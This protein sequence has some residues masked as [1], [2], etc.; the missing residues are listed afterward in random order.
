[1]VITEALTADLLGGGSLPDRLGYLDEH[2]LASG[3]GLSWILDRAEE[4]VH[5][6]PGDADELARLCDASASALGLP[7]ITGRARYL[8]ARVC[9]ERGELEQALAL[10]AEAHDAW[11]FAGDGLSAI[12]TNLGRMGVLD[13]LGRHRESAS[14]GEDLLRR[15]EELV[16]NDSEAELRELI[17]GTTLN[18][19]GV[20]YSFVGQHERALEAY[21]QAEATY[22]RLD[23]QAEIGKP[24]ANRGI[25]Q[26]ALGRS[27]EALEALAEATAVFTAAGDPLWAAKCAGNAA[28]A[29][30]ELGELTEALR[31]LEPA[32][33]TLDE[34]G[35]DM[36][37]HRLRQTLAEV[38]LAAGLLHQA[39][40][41]AAAVATAT[42][43]AG[44]A[45]DAGRAHFTLSLAHVLS[46]DLKD[47]E[48]EMRKARSLFDSV[49]DR[50]HLARL[51]LAEVDVLAAS[52]RGDLA[53]NLAAAAVAALREGGWRVPLAW[54]T[55]RQAD[56]ASEP[57]MLDAHLGAAW[58][59]VEELDLPPL[60]YAYLLRL[61]LRRRDQGREKEAEDALREAIR[62]VEDLGAALPDEA[63]RVAFRADKLAAHDQLVDLLVDRG[64][65]SSL[66]EARVIGDR[67]KAQTLVDLVAGTLGSVVAKEIRRGD[68]TDERQDRLRADL[69]ATYAALL[70]AEGSSRRELVRQ[71]SRS[72]ERQISTIRLRRMSTTR[73]IPQA[74]R[75]VPAP[76]DGPENG[77]RLSYHVIG[78]DIIAFVGT[79]R[80]VEARRLVE[81]MPRVCVELD[82]L[83]A[84][85]SRF[86]M[87]SAMLRRH[88][89][90]LQ[91]TAVE[92]LGVLHR[93][94]IQPVEDLLDPGAGHRLTVVPH[95]RLHQVPF[96]ALHDGQ[97]F[98]AERWAITLAGS[99]PQPTTHDGSAAPRAS[100]F[101]GLGVP[102]ARAPLVADELQAI[103]ALVP[104]ARVAVGE[105]ATSDLLASSL[106]GPGL[107]H[108]ASHGLHRADNPLFSAIRL[109]DRWI[110]CAEI[111]ELDLGGAVVTLSAC[112]SGSHG[113]DSAEPVGLAWAFLAAGASSVVVS[114]WVV[115][116]RVAATLMPSFYRHLMEGA[117]PPEALRFAQLAAL[118]HAP[119]PYFWGAF[120]HV[121]SPANPHWSGS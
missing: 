2:G 64:T 18:N 11:L 16:V 107:L 61:G 1:M 85:W 44:M 40:D 55:L 67:A 113:G 5:L 39:R 109:S 15:L 72:I 58:E 92:I 6:K 100:G 32:R 33:A 42:T 83:S 12:R 29:H 56:L 8:T 45:H 88:A 52:G 24:L 105:E 91:Q 35:A 98:L 14:V 80:G 112:E 38:Y 73:R 77:P 34:L 101:L 13:D 47:A 74:E 120:T 3:E 50:Q 106:P 4:L 19:L 104:D 114:Q 96:H 51:M 79:G 46:G 110:T 111:L 93:L 90:V 26:L 41:E 89:A 71:R 30:H 28:A 31:I 60:R 108:I 94:L 115:D 63:L 68:G 20:A 9:A 84:Q 21:A 103:A 102:D 36:E 37:A 99:T 97:A 116:D 81:A 48:A 118:D 7:R 119:H 62:V 53:S 49:G 66:A 69:S 22:R 43:A 117:E 23:K 76:G 75:H 54:G 87:G 78:S 59:L 95:R 70:R 10:I 121:T 86:S 57:R 17:R 27:R 25:E 82:R 65:P